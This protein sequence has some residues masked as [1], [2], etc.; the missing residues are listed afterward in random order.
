[1]KNILTKYKSNLK[2]N[3]SKN[4]MYFPVLFSV[5]I[6]ATSTLSF[7]NLWIYSIFAII[8]LAVVACKFYKNKKHLGPTIIL[9]IMFLGTDIYIK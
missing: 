9:L 2:S 5:S 8:S 1:M 4:M 7:N 3:F 6:M